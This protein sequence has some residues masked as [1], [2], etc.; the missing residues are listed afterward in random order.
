MPAPM[1]Q[2][3]SN[4][5]MYASMT[6]RPEAPTAS[7]MASAGGRHTTLGWPLIELG[8]VVVIQ[9]VAHRAVHE[10]RHR[11]GRLDAPSDDGRR[12]SAPG[13]LRETDQDIRELFL[14]SGER[15]RDA[16][17]DA[18]PCGE[19]GLLRKV[20]VRDRGDELRD[21]L[22]ETHAASFGCVPYLSLSARVR[23]LAGRRYSALIPCS[24]NTARHFLISLFR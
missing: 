24:L 16:V 2:P 21:A 13:V 23:H 22:G 4:A 7:P 9:R 19:D 8:D 15:A 6:S 11:R 3:T 10:R 20:L 5:I 12:V 1:A 18:V 17:D 14:R